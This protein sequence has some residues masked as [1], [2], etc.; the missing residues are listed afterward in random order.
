MSQLTAGSRA[1]DFSLAADDG[2]TFSLAEQRGK[3]VV[4]YFYPKDNTPGCTTEAKDF[5]DRLAEFEAANTRV[6]G[7]S[8]D[9]IKSHCNFRD[10][11]GLGFRLLSDDD[12]MVLEAY[13][14]WG[15]KKMYGRSFMGVIRST[16]LINEEGDLK[17]VWPKVRI[18][19]HVEEVLEA[20]RS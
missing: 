16:F 5:H 20:A 11:Y 15:E 2:S 3:Q 9:S 19:G 1:P 14:A 13:G 17:A 10:K 7:I 4:V 6:V 18:K 8:P 12:R